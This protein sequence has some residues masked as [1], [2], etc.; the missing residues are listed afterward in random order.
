MKTVAIVTSESASY[1]RA[2]K[3]QPHIKVHL[4]S[5]EEIEDFL[6]GKLIEASM[7]EK[8]SKKMKVNTVKRKY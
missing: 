2:L 8:G 5:D 6:L 1:L 7:N 4:V 3:K